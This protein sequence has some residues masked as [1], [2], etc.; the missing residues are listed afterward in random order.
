MIDSAMSDV[1]GVVAACLH[2]EKP[3]CAF[4]AMPVVVVFHVHQAC[5]AL[6][7][8]VPSVSGIFDG[9]PNNVTMS[10][11]LSID[12]HGQYLGGVEQQEPY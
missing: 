5:I 1:S 2:L 12:D 4:G 3:H 6:F 7:A 10:G 11:E 8:H 9:Q